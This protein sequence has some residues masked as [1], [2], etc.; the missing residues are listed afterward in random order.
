MLG[1]SS[2]AAKRGKGKMRPPKRFTPVENIDE[3]WKL[4]SSALRE[5]QN[6]NASKLSYEAL[7][8]YSYDMV[9]YHNGDRLYK[10]VTQIIAQHLDA[11]AERDIVP[12]FPRTGIMADTSTM[13][14]AGSNQRS[15]GILGGTRSGENGVTGIGGGAESAAKESEAVEMA[16]EGER[17][18]RTIKL[19]WEDHVAI[20]KKMQLVLKYMDKVYTPSAKVP[21]SFSLGLRQFER[22]IIH[23]PLFPI[24]ETLISVLLAQIQLERRGEVIHRSAVRDAISILS[25]LRSPPESGKRTP[26][27]P[28]IYAKDFEAR[29]LKTS[30]EFYKLEAEQGLST[31]DASAYLK[32]VEERLVEEQ[33]RCAHYLLSSTSAPLIA[34][35]DSNLLSA[36]LHT[37][38][39]MPE[40]GLINM[41]DTMRIPDLQRIYRLYGRANVTEGLDALMGELKKYVSTKGSAINENVAAG[42]SAIAGTNVPSASKANTTVLSSSNKLDDV[43]AQGAAQKV[44][45]T[46]SGNNA[47]GMPAG[48]ATSAAAAVNIALRWV[49][50]VLDLKDTFDRVWKEAFEEDKAIQTALNDA[51]QS[52]INVNPKAQEYIS[53]FIDDNLKK[54]LKGK[55]DDEIEAV[56]EKTIVLFRFIIDKDIFERYYKS[57]LAKRLLNGRSVSE[58][59]ERNMVAKLKVESGYSFTQKLEGMFNDMRLSSD[60]MKSFEK[61]Q[62]KHDPLDLDFNVN[63]LT[64]TFWPG[65][66]SATTCVFPPVFNRAIKSFEMFYNGRHS[67]RRLTWQS[68]HGT[69]DIRVAF[70]ARRHELN[71]STHCAVILL[72]FENVEDGQ[73]LSLQDIKAATQIPDSD[74]LRN[75]QSLACAKFKILTKNPKSRDVGPNDKFSFNNNFTCPLAKIKIQTIVGRVENTE[76][77]AETQEKVDEE[78]KH[79]IEACI[80]RIMK[81]K[82][83]LA[84][85]ELVNEVIRQLMGRFTPTPAVIKQRIE[86]LIDREYLERTEDMRSYNYLA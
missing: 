4:L 35:L 5:I 51:F 63:V 15:Q 3:T 10:G 68:N 29:F 30:E 28:S 46:H 7:Y 34:I 36:H 79:Q 71:V 32:R 8:R 27:R 55:T 80:V 66:G 37:V 81:D 54:G 61:F 23:S 19:V 11:L 84:H 82:K 48:T 47:A 58:D 18:L 12:T 53:L 44:K 6:H 73:E 86:N 85:S 42:T 70:K 52:F 38:L 21:N 49:Q 13:A 78:R 67:G 59:A 77:R 2:L 41:I 62:A 26:E 24:G 76:E 74:L 9:L 14:T 20:M 39:R 56:L 16:L 45:G 72:L 83:V 69:A 57:H 40:T 1:G 75:L 22:R 50:E 64:S 17:F 43:N 33:A 25:T 31:D 60:M 65:E